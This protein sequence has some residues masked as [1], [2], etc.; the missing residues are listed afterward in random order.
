MRARESTEKR[1]CSLSAAADHFRVAT[2][3]GGAA[4]SHS[5]FQGISDKMVGV[6]TVKTVKGARE[7]EMEAQELGRFAWLLAFGW[8]QDS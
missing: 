4:Q 5:Q 7:V 1:V 6:T 2:N 3:N 8:R